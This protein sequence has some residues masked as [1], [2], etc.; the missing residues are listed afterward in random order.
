MLFRSISSILSKY[1]HA[2]PWGCLHALACRYGTDFAAHRCGRTTDDPGPLK[3]GRGH[4]H[5]SAFGKRARGGAQSA[6]CQPRCPCLADARIPLFPYKRCRLDWQ[7]QY[8]GSLRVI[9]SHG[10]PL[11]ACALLPQRGFLACQAWAGHARTSVRYLWRCGLN[12]GL[13]GCMGAGP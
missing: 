9:A 4:L 7:A 2:A 12:A 11:P 3:M 5:K 8:C 13:S 10:S 1:A 6:P